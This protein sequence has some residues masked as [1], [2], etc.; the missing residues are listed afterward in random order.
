MRVSE[1][2]M[3]LH[4]ITWLLLAAAGLHLPAVGIS[5]AEIAQAL[6]ETPQA[7]FMGATEISVIQSWLG[8]SVGGVLPRLG[9][10]A[11]SIGFAVSIEVLARSYCRL[12]ALRVQGDGQ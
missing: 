2:F 8:Q 3:R 1:G 11:V 10:M 9:G 5:M 12:R 4:P 6:S 7:S